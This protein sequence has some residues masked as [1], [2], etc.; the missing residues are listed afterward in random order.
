MKNHAL[1][2]SRAG[3]FG[4]YLWQRAIGYGDNQAVNAGVQLPKHSGRYAFAG[5]LRRF[6]SGIDIAAN[7]LNKI[8]AALVQQP[9]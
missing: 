7:H 3:N 2:K 6:A 8:G 4:N 5:K 1:R 9:P